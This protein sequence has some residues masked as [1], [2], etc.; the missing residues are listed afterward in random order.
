[1]ST[2]STYPR[3]RHIAAA[4]AVAALACLTVSCSAASGPDTARSAP[5]AEKTAGKETAAAETAADATQE[6]TGPRVR[7]AFAGLQTTLVAPCADCGDNLDR[8]HLELGNLD[9]AMRKDPQG[10]SHFAEPL[11]LIGKLNET[12]GQDTSTENLRTH[13]KELFDTR[14]RINTWM[15]GHP[16]DYR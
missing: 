13:Q 5:A 16:E 8:V 4:T 12:L 1:M 15:Q 10:S 7:D 3:L 11:E 14:D 2:A 6:F 9:R